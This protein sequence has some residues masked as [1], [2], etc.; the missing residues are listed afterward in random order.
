MAKNELG[1]YCAHT[2]TFIIVHLQF[3]K[4]K[5]TYCEEALILTTKEISL[6]ILRIGTKRLLQTTCRKMHT[7]TVTSLHF[8]CPYNTDN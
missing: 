2:N 4:P 8:A 3:G 7:I 1:N 6:E 5:Q